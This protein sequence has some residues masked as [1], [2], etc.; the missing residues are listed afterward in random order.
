VAK[1]LLEKARRI[2]KR[3]WKSIRGLLS[4]TTGLETVSDGYLERLLSQCQVQYNGADQ[5][6]PNSTMAYL[7]FDTDDVNT[8]AM[9]EGVTN[10][11]RITIPTTGVYI[12]GAN[13]RWE[14][15]ANGER[16]VQIFRNR[17]T[18]LA[19]EVSGVSGAYFHTFSVSGMKDLTAGW[20]L[21]VGVFQESGGGTLDVTTHL[22]MPNFWCF[23]IA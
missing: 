13:A 7:T 19:Q 11:S 9:W 2:E 12:F 23:Q 4:R 15:N 22:A 16:R 5:T 18:V 6:I 10:P 14:N 21:E 3:N 1:P 8:N 17:V 20:Y